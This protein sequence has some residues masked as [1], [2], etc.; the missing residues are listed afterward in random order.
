M[1]NV[2]IIGFGLLGA[3]FGLA[4]KGK[5]YHRV[6]CTRNSTARNWALRENAADEVC[7]DPKKAIPLADIT[8]MALPIPVILQ[9]VH[10]YATLWKENSIVTDMGSVK[11][12][13][14]EIA[15]REFAGRKVQFVGGHPMAGTEFSGHE[16]A[17]SS[18]FKGADVFLCP[19]SNTSMAAVCQIKEIWESVGTNVIPL[20]PEEHDT[21]VS[22]TSHVQHIVASALTLTVLGSHDEREKML[23][24]AGCASGFRDTSRIA[25]S[26]PRMW[27]EIVEMNTPAILTALEHFE[28]KLAELHKIIATG[29]YDEFERQFA[30][31]K[32][33]R[34][35][36]MAEKSIPRNPVMKE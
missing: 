18:M 14:M 3:S 19:A 27:R 7:D 6:C 22:H 2:L 13:V 5:G 28:D 8:F 35:T 24:A 23:R 17:F 20:S 32:C 4:L 10:D 36:W 12:V 1:I 33:L 26:N 25:S 29:D 16:H 30:Y 11:G 34:D 9:Y 15:E 31:G 21:L